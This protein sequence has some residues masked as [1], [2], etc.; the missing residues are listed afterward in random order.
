MENFVGDKYLNMPVNMKR[1]ITI[2]GNVSVLGRYQAIS[3]YLFTLIR[4]FIG[5]HFL[6]EGL[7][8]L[9]WPW[10]SAGY[11]MESQ[12][13]FSG[14]FH[15][16]A[17]NPDVLHVVD[18]LNIVGLMLVGFSLFLGLLTKASAFTG[19]LLVIVYYIANPPF[20]GFMSGATGEGHYLVVNKQLIEIAVLF[21]F[22]F[23]PPDFFWSIDQ[24]IVRIKQRRDDE[25]DMNQQTFSHQEEEKCLKI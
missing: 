5:W 16:I 9:F 25:M 7:I 15:W 22:V 21:V 13:L 4:I 24:W 18:I 1:L 23:L 2:S 6:Y 3:E 14:I 12:W 20:I 17:E 11:L 10:S 8:K 19:A